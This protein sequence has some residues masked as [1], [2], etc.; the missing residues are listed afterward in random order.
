MQA[1]PELHAVDICAF[2]NCGLA[3]QHSPLL[4][5][6]RPLSWPSVQKPVCSGRK[7]SPVLHL[8]AY[9]CTGLGGGASSS[10]KPSWL[11]L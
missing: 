1:H 5:P 3:G 4:S 7:S 9:C 11:V 10:R 2:Q 6:R 8:L